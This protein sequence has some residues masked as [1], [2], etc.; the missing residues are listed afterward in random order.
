[1]ILIY[2]QNVQNQSLDFLNNELGS[3]YNYPTESNSSESDSSE[4]DEVPIKNVP[5][6]NNVT[7][8]NRI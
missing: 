4:Q 3:D 6:L 1:M 8:R 7:K 2:I 5:I